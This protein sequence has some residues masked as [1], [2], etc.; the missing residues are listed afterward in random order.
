M[1][2]TTIAAIG[3][4]MAN[5]T[6]YSQG[7]DSA[8]IYFQKGIEE[9][10]A[11]HFLQASKH[12]DKAIQFNANYKEA[13]LENGY[14]NLEMRKTDAARAHFTKVYEM[15]PNNM[16]AVKELMDLSYNYRQFAK[17]SELAA[18]CKGCQGT[19]KVL[20]M[21]AYQQEDYGTAIKMLGTYLA[22]N[23]TDAEATYIMAR[24][25]L[26]MEDYKGAVPFYNKA[27]ALDTEK[28][29]WAYELGLLYYN[30]DDFK[31]A[32]VF[33]NKAAEKGYNRSNDFNENLGY[34]NIYAGNFDEGE[35]L[36]LQVLQRKPNNKEL[37][38]DMAEAYYKVN[39][40]NKSLDYCQKLMEMDMK[41]GKALYQAGLCFQKMG[42]KD[43]G[44]A[45]CDK[46]IEM[47]PS[48]NNLRQKSM[49][50]GL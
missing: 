39:N 11:K 1:K 30:N 16:A 37:L 6:S 24:S 25:H 33:F 40:F 49:T 29:A 31:N 27:V 7:T 26:D 42:Q 23:P 10:T 5:L 2:K 50:M 22:K 4:I 41:D 34:A 28:N 48:L 20:G 35:K 47:D 36:L 43:K 13:Y 38:R 12:F 44:Q 19:D 18:K 8:E 14:V 9:K 17:A 15:D 46:A 21:S 3:L 32:V 45:M